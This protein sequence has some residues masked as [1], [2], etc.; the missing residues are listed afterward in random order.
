V[1]LLYCYLGH[2]SSLFLQDFILDLY[3]ILIIIKRCLDAV[4]N[5]K[6][7]DLTKRFLVYTTLA[8]AVHL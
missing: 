1:N 2:I 5:L 3:Y 6:D 8:N 4:D 7:L